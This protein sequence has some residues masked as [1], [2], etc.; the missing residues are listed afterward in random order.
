MNRLP[1]IL[2]A[3]FG[4]SA[5]ARPAWALSEEAREFL[6]GHR[7]LLEVSSDP[8]R[9]APRLE[10]E[11]RRL[12]GAALPGQDVADIRAAVAG[13]PAIPLYLAEGF[14]LV[15]GFAIYDPETKAVYLSS[16][17]VTGRLPASGGCPSDKRI[18]SLARDTAGIY[19]HEISH[20]LDQRALGEDA[21]TTS[22]GE[23]LAYAREARFLAGLKGWPDKTVVAELKRRAKLD[24][25]IARNQE[26]IGRL[27][28]MQGDP[29][30]ENIRKLEEYLPELED[31]RQRME[32]LKEQETA[33]DPLQASLADMVE[34][35]RAGW[36]EFL[37]LMI[38][39]TRTRPSL[40][41]REENLETARRF[42]ASSRAG[43]KDETPG[44][45]A[46]QVLERSVRL[47]EQ[48]VRFWGD[49]KTVKQALE[50]YK[51]RFKAV[52]PA[53]KPA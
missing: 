48:D 41:R 30:S 43:L 53:P 14:R 11:Y 24:K 39:Q 38:R 42:L 21:V 44:T 26:I 35:W 5:S 52:R 15:E 22:E 4:L 13:K 18:R 2:L 36:P 27:K 3:L 7:A 45:L 1:A 8:C 40:S 49:E 50:F 19:V 51:R 31:I 12:L 29:N 25:L 32:R 37:R 6:R 20:A 46:H 28:K 34:S 16:A 23:M 47:G 9:I 33:V 17:A 10:A